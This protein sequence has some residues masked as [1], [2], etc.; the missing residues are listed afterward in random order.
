MFSN[1]PTGFNYKLLAV[2]SFLQQIDKD[3]LYVDT[4]TCCPN[5]NKPCMPFL[6]ISLTLYP[7]TLSWGAIPPGGFVNLLTLTQRQLQLLVCVSASKPK[8]KC[9]SCSLFSFML[10]WHFGNGG[11][12]R[13]RKTSPENQTELSFPP[14]TTLPIHIQI[15][16][17]SSVTSH[18]GG[19]KMTFCTFLGTEEGRE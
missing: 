11:A 14:P 10:H 16:L 3:L 1:F 15:L 17:L 5:T 18:M 12:A 13:R 6:V 7:I 9:F 19:T 8:H 4:K 2:S